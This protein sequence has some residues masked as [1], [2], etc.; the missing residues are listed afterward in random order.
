MS[1][2]IPRNIEK[3]WKPKTDWRPAKPYPHPAP[4]WLP[5]TNHI[6]GIV[7]DQP[8]LTKE[9]RE[10]YAVQSAAYWAGVKA[11]AKLRPSS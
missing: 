10:S 9:L 5:K 3:L 2:Q 11:R 8:D 4:F 7:L 1:T 6:T